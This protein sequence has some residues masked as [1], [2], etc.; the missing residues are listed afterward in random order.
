MVYKYI[1]TSILKEKLGLRD[2]RE[3]M[4][5]TGGDVGGM[6]SWD[7]V[8]KGD[9]EATDIDPKSAPWLARAKNMWK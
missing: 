1:T 9:F 8:M 3:V 5:K 6:K 2:I 7:G 4:L